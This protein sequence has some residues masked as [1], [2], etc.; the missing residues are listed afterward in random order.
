MDLIHVADQFLFHSF[1]LHLLVLLGLFKRIDQSTVSP[2]HLLDKPH[3][4]FTHTLEEG[5]MEGIYAVNTTGTSH[6]AVLW[7]TSRD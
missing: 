1:P 4:I 3:E 2:A 5:G 6:M 7:S